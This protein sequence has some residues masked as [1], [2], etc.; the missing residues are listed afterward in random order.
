MRGKIAAVLIV[1]LLAVALALGLGR[2]PGVDLLALKAGDVQRRLL[3]DPERADRRIVLIEVDQASLDHFERDNIAYPWPR[4]LYNPLL[5][6][7][8]RGGATAVLFDVLFNNL[9]P[10][11][12]RRT[13][14]LRRESAGTATCFWRQLPRARRPPPVRLTRA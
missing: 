8:A 1:P 11:G 9:S 10:W 6:Y 3:A 13:R 2:V 4:S 5:E 7:C 14:S 12:R